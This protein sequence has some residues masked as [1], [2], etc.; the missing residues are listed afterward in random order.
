MSRYV[1]VGL[2]WHAH[3][4]ILMHGEGNL[5]LA[6][7]A[8][9]DYPEG[10]QVKIVIFHIDDSEALLN[11]IICNITIAR[12]LYAVTHFDMIRNCEMN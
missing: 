9:T 1:I 10:E 4:G 12:N 11:Q 8:R 5:M 3:D 7:Y 6:T 2:I